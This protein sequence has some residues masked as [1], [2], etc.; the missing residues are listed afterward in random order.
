M[1]EDA[2]S[3]KMPTAAEVVATS[4]IGAH[5]VPD[6]EG[7][8]VAASGSAVDLSEAKLPTGAYKPV[9]SAGTSVGPGSV[10]MES[11]DLRN[12]AASGDAAVRKLVEMIEMLKGRVVQTEDL[13]SSPGGRFFRE[14]FCLRVGRLEQALEELGTYPRELVAFADDYEGIATQTN[15]TATT[16]L[17][18]ADQASWANV[19]GGNA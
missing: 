13:W 9:V 11:Q 1:P 14:V 6:L 18:V 17:E 2:G 12:A 8:G 15:I 5:K 16:I 19:T 7:L 4:G 10:K 3:T